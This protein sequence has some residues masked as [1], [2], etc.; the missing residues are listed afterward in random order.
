MPGAAK[1]VDKL[2]TLN[3]SSLVTGPTWD[4]YLAGPGICEMFTRKLDAFFE[5][6]HPA[7]GATCTLAHG[8]LRGDNIYFCEPSVR[9]PDGWLCIDF[10]LMHRGPVPSDLAYLMSS[11]T[12]LPEVYSGENL[13]RVL[14]TFYEQFMDKTAAYKDYTYER[15]VREFAIMTTVM[16]VYAVGLG[17]AVWQ[18]SAFNNTQAARIK[19]GDHGSTEAD[20]TPEELRQR[21]WWRKLLAN[22]RENFKTFDQY[23]ELKRLPENLD[24]LGAWTD[25][26]PHLQ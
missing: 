26:P 14:K 6:V 10:Q 2:T 1:L 19:L 4:S 3:G 17:A 7:N 12:V 9:Y 25:L 23:N 20:L 13:H 11:A 18:A 15:F 8:D 5:T 16:F 22:C 24:G 21:M